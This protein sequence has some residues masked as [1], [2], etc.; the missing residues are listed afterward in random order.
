MPKCINGHES[1]LTLRCEVCG[2]AVLYKDACA[3]LIEIPTVEVSF[4]QVSMLYVGFP[5]LPSP[6]VYIAQLLIGDMEAAGV[7]SFVVERLE[8]GTW[9]DFQARYLKKFE[10]WLKLVEFRKS[11]YRLIVVDTTNPLSVLAL[12]SLPAEDDIVVF[13]IIAETDSTPLEQHTS[14]VALTAAFQRGLPLILLTRSFRRE[15]AFFVEH[16]GFVVGDRALGEIISFLLASMRDLMDFI[17]RD[18]RLGVKVHVFSALMAA[19]VRVYR[20]V[21]DAFLVQRHQISLDPES[22]EIE[23]AYLMAAAGKDLDSSIV[24]GFKQYCGRNLVNLVSTEHRF[25]EKDSKYGLY[26][27]VMLY[28]LKSIPIYTKLRKAYEIVASRAQDLKV[29]ELL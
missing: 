23:T 5:T 22:E 10:R 27:I 1:A 28:G 24:Q 9:L 29:E 17:Q 7:E 12:R 26:N 16:E 4:E 2:G 8:G 21:H 15:V 13:A 25:Y 11:R 18:S 6:S 14:Y 3:E 19:S 20:T